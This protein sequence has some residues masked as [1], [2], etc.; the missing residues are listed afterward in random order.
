MGKRILTISIIALCALISAQNK[1]QA[2]TVTFS[3]NDWAT[4]QGLNSGDAVSTITEAPVTVAFAQGSGSAV[5]YNG[6]AI[7]AGEGNTLTITVADGYQ[8]ASATL[9]LNVAAQAK[10]L[11][12]NTWS[13]GSALQNTDNTKQVDWTG[14]AKS[15]TVTMTGTEVFTSFSVTYEDQNRLYTVTF[16]GEDG[17]ILKTESVLSGSSATPPSPPTIAG[18]VF[19]GWDK[20]YTNIT[21]DVT[22]TAQY[23]FDSS[24]LNETTTLFI[25]DMTEENELSDGEE[26]ETLDYTKNGKT[27]L[28]DKGTGSTP[29]YYQSYWGDDIPYVFINTGNT[30]TISSNNMM[31][32]IVIHINNGWYLNE[33]VEKATISSGEIRKGDEENTVVW[34]GSTGKLTI[35]DNG[36]EMPITKI[37]IYSDK[38][39]DK[40]TVNFFGL[41]GKL[42]K[43]EQ[44][45]MGS[46]ATA[47]EI[48][49]ECFDGWDHDFSKVY[50]DMDIYPLLATAYELK[51]TTWKEKAERINTY[52]EDGYTFS[53]S[54]NRPTWYNNLIDDE[55][56]ACLVIRPDMTLT[57]SHEEAFQNLKIVCINQERASYLAASTCSNG[58]LTQHGSYVNWRGNTKELS[59]TYPSSAADNADIVSFGFPCEYYEIVPCTVIFLDAD[60][61]EIKRETVM[62]G[63]SV[64]PPD[65]TAPDECHNFTG[66]DK[67]LSKVRGDMTVRPVLEPKKLLSLSAKN[68]SA[69]NTTMQ[70]VETNGYSFS[71]PNSVLNSTKQLIDGKWV[72][73]YYITVYRGGKISISSDNYVRNIT[74]TVLNEHDAE[75]L[76]AAAFSQG[77]ATR[78]G[79]RVTWTGVTDRLDIT[80]PNDDNIGLSLIEI[81]CE[82]VTDHTVIILDKDGMVLK[83]VTVADGGSVTPPEDQTPENECY[84]F[85]GWSENLT[86]IR[87]DLT[88]H[89]IFEF[90]GGCTPEGFVNVT[91]IDFFGDIIESSFVEIGGT[92][93]APKVPEL[94]FHTFK[95]WDHPLDNIK[96]E[97][98]SEGPTDGVRVKLDPASCETWTEVYLFEWDNW[99]NQP[100]GEWPGTKVSKDMYGWWS[101]TYEEEGWRNIIWNN[102]KGE[103]TVDINE[104]GESTCYQ[105]GEKNGEGKFTAKAVDC[106]TQAPGL[107]IRPLYTF[108]KDAEEIL[109]VKEA[110]DIIDS[111][112]NQ[113][114]YK[115]KHLNDVFAAKG[116]VYL[117]S[118]LL[119]GG[120]LSVRI[121]EDG[122]YDYGVNELRCY[123]MLGPDLEQ[124]VSKMQLQQGDTVILFGKFIQ[125]RFG[126]G[127]SS[128]GWG[129][130]KGYIPYIGKKVSDDGV[131][132][133]DMPDAAT[134]YDINGDG[135][136]QAL[137]VSSDNNLIVSGDKS[138]NFLFEKSLCSGLPSS[139]GK[140]AFFLSDINH[141]D[142]IDLGIATMSNYGDFSAT[143]LLSGDE[144][145]KMVNGS[146][147]LPQF[148]LNGD[149]RTD[150]LVVDPKAWFVPAFGAGIII[151][152]LS[153]I[154]P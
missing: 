26:V 49:H 79:V 145:Y 35:Q 125:D 57:V 112:N 139:S 77:S 106:P 114:G 30:V 7:A 99:G 132:Y 38:N 4:A 113:Y 135:K 66:W 31:H 28:F 130:G 15:V 45:N 92:A 63:E 86:N 40:A 144:G 75:N 18:K 41:D 21:E 94:K 105:L 85:K 91:F 111:L 146:L 88:V 6:S 84:V 71:T 29:R 34:E 98:V 140:K 151:K 150:H 67:D 51:A 54:A 78:D 136:K 70:D 61:K 131:V 19:K 58:K 16:V 1:G 142:D 107:I 138:N 10:R 44:V 110:T 5:T 9:T 120:K 43:T 23:D 59:I 102:G 154:G 76:A 95:G 109:S 14:P 73:I 127:Y 133:I 62:A 116:I 108:N 46:K 60:G 89:P 152:C 64:T 83:S 82:I 12:G 81:N 17:A 36:G 48:T 153:K 96:A 27:V 2:Q 24:V 8:L 90:I 52:T 65:Y 128:K 56:V 104:V 115:E 124:F 149:G 148:D 123:S 97:Q 47:P 119:D 53:V 3:A 80:L 50:S 33:F 147:F 141:D 121:T 25:S 13:A 32:R 55:T 117:V 122:Q 42:L 20:D 101:Y 39:N 126:D 37:I 72:N 11:A 22:I 103:Q 118:N 134:M 129:L 74:F 93:I 137:Y 87:T 69:N 100:L 143:S 68:D